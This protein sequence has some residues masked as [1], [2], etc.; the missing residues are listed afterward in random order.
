MWPHLQA[1]KFMDSTNNNK[2]NIDVSSFVSF[3]DNNDDFLSIPFPKCTTSS[4]DI[5]KQ[6]LV[7]NLK[8]NEIVAT[9]LDDDDVV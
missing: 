1:K 8:L 5:N 6:Y 2:R 4:V 9:S 3:E 7:N